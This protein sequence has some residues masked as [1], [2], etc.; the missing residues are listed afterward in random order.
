MLEAFTT[1]DAT[2]NEIDITN[3]NFIN[4]REEVNNGELLK[5]NV[6]TANE[7]KIDED[8]QIN[9]DE[10]NEI[11]KNLAKCDIRQLKYIKELTS[12]EFIEEME[13]LACNR[14]EKQYR[15]AVLQTVVLGII[16]I[17]I[18]TSLVWCIGKC[19]E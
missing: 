9:V 15:R 2:N 3:M 18:G 11:I 16:G 4:N 14:A 6:A 17:G 13:I 19:R 7:V 1:S 10:A 5:I 8:N 12:L